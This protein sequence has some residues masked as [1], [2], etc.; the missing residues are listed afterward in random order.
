MLTANLYTPR[1]VY[2]QVNITGKKKR[3]VTSGMLRPQWTPQ[4]VPKCIKKEMDVLEC[5]EQRPS[6]LEKVFRTRLKDDTIDTLFFLRCL[7]LDEA[8]LCVIVVEINR[9]IG[10]KRGKIIYFSWSSRL[11]KTRTLRCKWLPI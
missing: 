11:I 10:R 3:D 6:C 2:L 4:Q 1:T 7:L 5:T 9:L 8:N